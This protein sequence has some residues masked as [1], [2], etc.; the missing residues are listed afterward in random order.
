MNNDRVTDFSVLMSKVVYVL[1]N[2]TDFG[3]WSSKGFL[4]CATD[5]APGLEMP[6]STTLTT[7]QQHFGRFLDKWKHTFLPRG[8]W[9]EWVGAFY[10]MC[11]A[12]ESVPIAPV[13]PTNKYDVLPPLETFDFRNG[14]A[15]KNAHKYVLQRKTIKIWYDGPLTNLFQHLEHNKEMYDRFTLFLSC[16]KKLNKTYG[17]INNNLDKIQENLHKVNEV[18]HEIKQW[19]DSLIIHFAKKNYKNDGEQFKSA[20]AL[21]QALDLFTN[22]VREHFKMLIDSRSLLERFKGTKQ[23]KCYGVIEEEKGSDNELVTLSQIAAAIQAK[24]ERPPKRACARSPHPPE[25][26][27][28]ARVIPDDEETEME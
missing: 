16:L 15:S 4:L 14:R 13:S 5:C 23:A 7:P 17:L 20:R 24:S 19:F 6:V 28:R 18:L 3:E 21:R 1:R 10:L 22:E 11:L 27:K 2:D 12:H 26:L 8:D 25:R 9:K